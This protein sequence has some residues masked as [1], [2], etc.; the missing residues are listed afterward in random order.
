MVSYDVFLDL[1]AT[2]I[3]G[4]FT[5]CWT[6]LFTGLFQT[7][8]I[9]LSFQPTVTTRPKPVARVREARASPRVPTP[10]AP[11]ALVHTG[12]MTALHLTNLLTGALWSPPLLHVPPPPPRGLDALRILLAPLSSTQVQHALCSHGHHETALNPATLI[13]S[14]AYVCLCLHDVRISVWISVLR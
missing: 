9:N 11:P 12:E 3:L 6:M 14:G 7:L 8:I 1:Q 13:L 2:L 10:P 4:Y 5:G